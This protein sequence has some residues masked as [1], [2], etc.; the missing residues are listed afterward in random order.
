MY[1]LRQFP[2]TSSVFNLE[3]WIQGLLLPGL[4]I[5]TSLKKVGL[6]SYEC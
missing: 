6:D 4:Q 5:G 3:K 1:D 2:F